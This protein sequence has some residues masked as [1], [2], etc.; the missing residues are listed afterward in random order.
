MNV[1]GL[2]G[3]FSHAILKKPD[4]KPRPK[5]PLQDDL[6]RLYFIAA[7][8]FDLMDGLFD[9]LDSTVRSKYLASTMCD[10]FRREIRGY[11]A[12]GY[13]V[14]PHKN[15]KIQQAKV[16]ML[17]LSL[18][19]RYTSLIR[20]LSGRLRFAT[21]SKNCLFVTAIRKQQQTCLVI[22]L[23]DGLPVASDG[24]RLDEVSCVCQSSG[25]M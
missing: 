14:Y 5:Y 25:Q 7:R 23:R 15:K 9:K 13:A 21:L 11:M 1:F 10:V 17:A 16:S 4:S 12:R 2:S 18:G 3:G 19:N 24:Q 20:S 6:P 22:I 8:D